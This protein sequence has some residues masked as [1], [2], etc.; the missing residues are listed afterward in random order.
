MKVKICGV[1]DKAAMQAASAAGADYVGICLYPPSPRAIS[2][3]DAARLVTDAGPGPLRVALMVD[4]DDDL[5]R[6]AAAIPVDMLQLHGSESP[7]RVEEIRKIAGR[8]VMK[9]LGIRD[10]E[11]VEKISFYEGVADQILI[12]AKPPRDASRPGGNGLTF[13]WRLL[14]DRTWTAPWMLSGGLVPE[15]VGD[16]VRLTGAR[17]VDVASGVESAPGIK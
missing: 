5:V 6:A 15:N 16:A 13:D 12:D 14:T 8:P 10:R 2:I 11:D 3:E 7:H 4:P 9:A 17:Q 1:N